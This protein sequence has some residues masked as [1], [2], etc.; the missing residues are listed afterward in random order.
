MSRQILIACAVFVVFTILCGVCY[1]LLVTAIA[2]AA[3]PRQAGGSLV[4]VGGRVVGSE[5][6]AQDFADPRYFHPRPSAVQYQPLPSGATN[7]GP[8]SRLLA[9]TAAIRRAKFLVD[10]GLPQETSVPVEML[11]ASGSG[12]DPHISLASALLQ[13]DR[14]A[15][16]RRLDARQLDT[17][18]ALISLCTECIGGA[19]QGRGYINVLRLNLALEER[20]ADLMEH[21]DA[22]DHQ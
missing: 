8:T 6:I 5:L 10:N 2:E 17:L 7:A 18:H 22:P 4:I 19:G 16:S 21:P 15:R 11:C 9:E 14:V 20:T 12:V 1:P 13:C 3:F